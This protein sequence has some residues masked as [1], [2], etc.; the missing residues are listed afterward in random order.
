ML[1]VALCTYNGAQFIQEQIQSI[2]NQTVPVD[3]IVVCDDGSTDDTL[4][5]IESFKDTVAVD[6]R[7]YRNATRLGPAK[8]F[9]QAINLCHGDII[10]LS[11]QDDIWMP[12]KVDTITSY[13]GAHPETDVVFTDA[14][15]LDDN[16]DSVIGTLWHSIGMTNQA[17]DAIANSLGIELFAYENRATG[18]TMAVRHGFT[19]LNNIAS[20]CNDTILHD[21][22]LAMIAVSN[23]SIGFISEKL[24]QYRIHTSQERGIGDS[25][26]NPVCDN[27]RETSHLATVWNQLAL[28]EPLASRIAFIV[29]RHRRKH[30][31]LGGFRLLR[32]IPTYHKMYAN[33]WF[34]FLFYDLRQWVSI[35]IG[36]IHK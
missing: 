5:I 17:K 25:I 33:H 8:N 1:S 35:M 7:I 9:Q 15:L 10:F 27:P 30:Q 19:C 21:G 32:G 2:L 18:A 24:I 26:D 23:N 16:T 28:P 6:I 22:A 13:F 12:N 36:R 3:E 11:D 20:Y 31:P 4:T 29:N 14:T 34:S